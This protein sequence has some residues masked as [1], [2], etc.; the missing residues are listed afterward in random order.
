[1]QMISRALP[2]WLGKVMWIPGVQREETLNTCGCGAETA[3]AGPD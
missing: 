1:M 3:A 2:F